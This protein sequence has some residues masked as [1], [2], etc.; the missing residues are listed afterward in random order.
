M[1]RKR[2]L[3]KLEIL[4]I[5]ERKGK[6]IVNRNSYR[7]SKLR[8]KLRKMAKDDRYP[9][10]FVLATQTEIHYKRVKHHERS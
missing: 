6:F 3:S 1:P 5:L 9:I 10:E 8:D 4:E 2:I 7:D